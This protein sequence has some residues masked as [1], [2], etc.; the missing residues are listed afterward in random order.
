MRQAE[1]DA[2]FLS[3]THAG[4]GLALGGH[5]FALDLATELLHRGFSP[6]FDALT[7]PGF[8]VSRDGGGPAP[9][10]GQLIRRGIRA[11]R[12]AICVVTKDYTRKRAPGAVN[13]TAEECAAIMERR[14]ASAGFRY[15]LVLRGGP[16]LPALGFAPDALGRPD[17]V[18]AEESP[19]VLAKQMQAWWRMHQAQVG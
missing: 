9:R 4:G 1:H 18:F 11:S 8:R 5:A 10:L 2:V 14:R 7:L 17:H 15:V 12:L 19:A 16:D 6:W 3:Y 13:W